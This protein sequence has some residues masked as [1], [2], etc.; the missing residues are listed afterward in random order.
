[1][2][3]ALNAAVDML[4]HN[5][6]LHLWHKR[7][8]PTCPLCTQN[9]TL[10][11]IL[12]NCPTARNLRRYNARHDAVLQEVS[13]AIVPKLPPSTTLTTDL[14]EGYSFP[15]HITPTDLRPDLVWWDDTSRSLCLAEL[16]VCYESNFE[17]AAKRKSAKYSDLAE[18]AELS[19]Y[20]TTLLTLQVGSRGVPHYDS[21][22]QLASA[23]NMSAKE[24]SLLLQK[25][26]RAALMGSFTIWCSRNK[27]SLSP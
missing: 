11:H 23:T 9:Q 4:P 7:G 1:M 26:T 3:F 21:F 16:T 17:E 2:K 15:L 18:Q 10:L 24:L 22:K 6:N 25:V 27:Q 12:N 20:S 19:G 14:G 8:D 13:S 5:A